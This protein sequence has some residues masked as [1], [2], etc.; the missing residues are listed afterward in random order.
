MSDTASAQGLLNA[1]SRAEALAAMEAEELDILIIGGGIVGAGCALDA[2]TRG[3]NVGVVEARTG[4]LEL[5]AVPPSWCTA[6]F[7][8][9]SS[10]TST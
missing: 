4:L 9:S 2:A 7:A 10:S 8:T 3:L 1:Q 6:V 5:L